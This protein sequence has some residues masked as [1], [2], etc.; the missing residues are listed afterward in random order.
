MINFGN[1]SIFEIFKCVLTHLS[2]AE[3]KIFKVFV[4]FLKKIKILL[5]KIKSKTCVVKWIFQLSKKIVF[6]FWEVF[7][8]KLKFFCEI[9]KKNPNFIK[10]NQ[11]K[12]MWSQIDLRNFTKNFLIFGGFCIFKLVRLKIIS[13]VRS[14]HH[15]AV[16]YTT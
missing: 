7:E 11:V 16:F 10:Q 13:Y 1:L 2:W 6:D 12:N 15:C 9:L 8:K 3:E 5:S 4:K 14:L